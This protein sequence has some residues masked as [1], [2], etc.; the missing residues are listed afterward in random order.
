MYEKDKILSEIVEKRL[1]VIR[2]F[3]EFGFG[4]KIVMRDFE[5]RGV[6]N[7]LGF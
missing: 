3:I 1:K 2:E 4:F 5:I 7:I 6:G